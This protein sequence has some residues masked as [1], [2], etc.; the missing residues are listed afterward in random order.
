MV[1]CKKCNKFVSLA[2]DEILKCKGTCEG[3]FHKKCVT[4]TTLKNEKCEDCVSTIDSSE[5]NDSNIKSILA[6]M[7]R[8]MDIIYNMEKKLSELTDLVDFISEKYDKICE[9]Q[10][11]TEKKIKALEN[12]NAYL[13]KCNKSLEERVNE[14]EE[15][16]KEKKV[17]LSGL[18]KK[19]NEDIS[20]VVA[21]LAQNLHLDTSE[22]EHAERVGREKPGS[23]KPALVVVTLKTK[24]ARNKWIEKR[25]INLTNGQIYGTNNNNRIYINENLT[26]YKRNL[27]WATKIQLKNIYKYIWVQDGKILI[28]KSDDQKKITSIRS[29]TDIQKIVNNDTSVETR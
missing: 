12:Q 6:D 24:N 13:E 20:K 17:E 8:K 2:K 19:N 10:S 29:E 22:I 4:K 1:Q 23:E 16:D 9:H 25:K 15:K 14:L 28:R 5:V 18:E 26:R 11:S 27:L 7:N 21:Q 3:V